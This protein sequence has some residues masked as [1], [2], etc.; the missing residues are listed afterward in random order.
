MKQDISCSPAVVNDTNKSET[1]NASKIDLENEVSK[2]YCLLIFMPKESNQTWSF[3]KS[4]ESLLTQNN[5]PNIQKTEISLPLM[6]CLLDSSLN[7]LNSRTE[8]EE[9]NNVNVTHS[10]SKVLAGNTDTISISNAQSNN[11]K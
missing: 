8:R 2:S 5:F 11:W 1:V 3:K 9:S 4:L 6:D 7:I 10:I